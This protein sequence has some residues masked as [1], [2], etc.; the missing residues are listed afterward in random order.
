MNETV[1]ITGATG[2]L[3]AQLTKDLLEHTTD[4]IIVLVRT[5][6]QSTAESRL[7]RCW[8]DWPELTKAIGS[9]VR[10]VGGDITK[11]LLGLD[12]P[13]YRQMIQSISQ[14]MHSAAEWRLE[15]QLEKHRRIN[16][17]GTKNLLTLA[18]LVHNDH[19][20]KRFVYVSTAYVAGRRQ[21]NILE[22]DSTAAYGFNNYY[23]QTK[24]EAETLVRQAG[25][26]IPITIFRPGMVV[27]DSQSGWI[28]TFN[29]MYFPLRLY[30]TG[31]LW[32]LPVSPTLRINL[33]PVDYVTGAIVKLSYKNETAGLTFHL[34]TPNTE[35]PTVR[36]FITEV[37]A[38]A[39]KQLHI[40]LPLPIFL[41][42]PVG[43]LGR[44][45][46][47]LPR[48]SIWRSLLLLSPYLSGKQNF[49]RSNTDLFY[50][51]HTP[52]WCDY[53]HP[54]LEY[55]VYHNFLHHSE[56]TVHEQLLFR[57]SS[58][59]RPVTYHDLTEGKVITKKAGEVRREII[60]VTSALRSLGVVPGDRIAVVG[61]NSIRFLIIDV[62]IGLTGAVS[63]PLYYT[64]PPEEITAIIQSCRASILFIGA[65]KI[66]LQLE[67][68]AVKHHIISFCRSAVP[69]NLSDKVVDW[70]DF[71]ALSKQ[72]L[73]K[74]PTLEKMTAPVGFGETA[75]LRYTSGTTGSP[76]GTVFQHQNLRFMAESLASLPPWNDRNRKIRYL[77]FLPM[78][79]VVE[80][81]LATYSLYYAPVP[82]DIY[83]LEDFHSLAKSLPKIRPTFFFSVPRFYEKVWENF[84]RSRAGKLYL[85]LKEGWFKK[86]LSPMLGKVLLRKSGLDK[87][88]QLIVGSAPIS[89]ELIGSY[90]RLGIEIHNAYGLTEAPLVTMNRSGFNRIGTVGTPLPQTKVRI[91][92]DGE[93]LV[94]GPQVAA[95][96]FG[97]EN[98]SVFD[99]G[100]LHTGD[101]GYLTSEGA[102]V[103]HSRK[104]EVII[105]SY[106]K[107][108]HPL[109][110]ENMLREIPGVAEVILLGNAKPYCTSLIWLNEGYFHET[111]FATLN[112]QIRE[113]NSQLSQPEQIKKWAYIPYNLSI[114]GGDLTANLKV[115][116]QKVQER[117]NLLIEAMYIET[118]SE[119]SKLSGA[120]RI[121]GYQESEI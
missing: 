77:S 67:N 90:Q 100:W 114:A 13:T 41:P 102:L 38:W 101:L 103:L 15:Q 74:N 35:I 10:V 29:T 115:K 58:G 62:A 69:A 119:Q 20:L 106:G 92:E 7:Y 121:F 118:S 65:P 120:E 61:L 47:F 5:S 60:R 104:K 87:C 55:A 112:Q 113:I 116:R 42:L 91:A 70:E 22:A 71:L 8:W 36:E 117:Y 84:N 110:I 53:I 97:E 82:V 79:H 56:R 83:F 50:G 66:L 40:K 108:I 54:L 76:K 45:I 107:N 94:N 9:R 88:A 31:K 63:V 3:G 21:G 109:K 6:N 4:D 68:L 48:K 32:L 39:I 17:D 24:Y 46:K 49:E 96:Y 73:S 89:T 80:G 26:E 86:F 72:N 85:R 34:T 81:I 51:N 43:K 95:G 44:L 28:K 18:G 98:K 14:I 57:L 33:I 30:L 19:G 78:N 2:F 93:V 105:T 37:R 64:S 52:N 59:S 27:G 75:T 25:S 23:E 11:P 1:F 16:V 111:Q 12:E 99:N